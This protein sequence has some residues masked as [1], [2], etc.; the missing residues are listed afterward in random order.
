MFLIQVGEI[1]SLTQMYKPGWWV[2][3]LL[4]FHILGTIIR[5]DWYYSEGL[6]PPTRNLY[7]IFK[8]IIFVYSSDF[9]RSP[10]QLLAGSSWL[11][12]QDSIA[13]GMPDG[14]ESHSACSAKEKVHHPKIEQQNHL[15]DIQCWIK[16]E[17]EN[18]MNPIIWLTSHL[19]QKIKWTRMQYEAL[20]VSFPSF[21]F[22]PCR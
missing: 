10:P 3:T 6:T 1:W 2:G 13:L 5:T 18:N 11:V 7:T 17:N 9:A 8:Y 21:P 14:P 22:T 20:R 19:K 4:L 15:V 12:N 16:K